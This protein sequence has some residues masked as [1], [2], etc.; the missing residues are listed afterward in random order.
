MASRP[1]SLAILGATGAVGRTVLQ[2]LEDRDTPVKSL[3]LLASERSQGT[4]L[5]FKGEELPVEPLK[6]GVFQGCDVAIFS[7]GSAVS[8]EWAPKAWAE[9]CAVVDNSSAFRADPE[10]P[11][12]VPEVNPEALAGFRAKGLVANPNCAVTP[13]LVA[14]QPLHRAAGIERLVVSTYQSVSGAGQKA[15]EQLEGEAHALMNGAEPD[16]PHQIPYR[17]AFNLV[18]QIGAFVEGGETEEERS[19]AAESRRILGA[20]GLRVSA[21]AVRVPIFYGHSWSVNLATGRKLSAGEARELLKQAPGVK[22]VDDL[23]ERIYPMPL[24]AVNDDA[25]LVGRVREDASQEHGLALFV[26][27]DNLRKGAATNAVQLAELLGEKYL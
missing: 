21:T 6:P 12:V 17:I 18:P 1:L 19:I 5:E 13:L 16:A 25:V 4:V 20:P 27:A 22:L 26:V 8:R 3:K 14:L 15:V 10:V 9:G 11:L 7:A 23:K 24:L 2:V